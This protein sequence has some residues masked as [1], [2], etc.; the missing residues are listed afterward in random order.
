MNNQGVITK[1]AVIFDMNGIIID[2][3][4]VHELAFQR[5]LKE[6]NILLNHSEY[7]SIFAGRTDQEGF[8]LIAHKYGIELPINEL[9]R[10][11]AELYLSLFPENK[12]TYPGVIEL[13]TMLSEKLVLALTSSSTRKEIDLVLNTFEVRDKFKIIVSA[14]DVSQGKPDPEPYLITSQKLGILPEFC[15]VIE[16]SRSGVRSAIDAGMK[17]IGVTTTH[18]LDALHAATIVVN[19]FDQI[20]EELISNL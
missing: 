14:E 19:N 7:I 13:I 16:D 9:L 2:D 11:K 8:E 10:K 17:C 3:E 18:D 4:H 5:V 15:V 12:K 1:K 6:Y 20:T